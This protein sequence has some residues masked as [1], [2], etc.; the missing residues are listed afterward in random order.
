MKAELENG[1]RA[2]LKKA[3]EDYTVGLIELKISVSGNYEP[4]QDEIYKFIDEAAFDEN[5]VLSP[6]NGVNVLYDDDGFTRIFIKVYDTDRLFD[7]IKE[8]E[9]RVQV[10][11]NPQ[12]LLSTLNKAITM[13]EDYNN[14][15]GDK[16]NKT[17]EIND[18]DEILKLHQD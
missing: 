16:H 6:D 7:Y 4:I 9:K 12:V 2:L 18:L 11:E 13:L 3:K 8:L 15:Y 17:Q 1:I 14:M 10:R 5:L